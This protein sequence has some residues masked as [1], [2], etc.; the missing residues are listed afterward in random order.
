MDIRNP[1]RRG[2]RALRPLA[3]ALG[4]CLFALSAHAQDGAAPAPEAAPPTE[5]PA[6]LPA[7]DAD[8][9]LPE[10]GLVERRLDNGLTVWVLPRQGG[11]PK[12]DFVLAVRGGLASD[13]TEL[14]GMSN[15]LAGLLQE[16][17]ATRSS[18]QIAE[19]LERLGAS[20]GASASSDGVFVSASGLSSSARPLAALFAD[21]VRNPAFPENEVQLAKVNALQSLKAMQA[22]P[23]YQANLAMGRVLYGS[24]PYGNTLPTEAGINGTDIAGLQA[25]H[26][27]RFHPER[28][29]LVIAGPLDADAAVA[30]ANQ[31]F[32]DWQGAAG[33]LPEVAAPD[34]PQAPQFVLVPRSG[35]VQSAVRIGRPAFAA[36]DERAIPAALANTILGGGFD[37][38]LMRNL[39]EEKG[40]TYGAGSSFGLRALGGAFQAQADV[41]N[42]VTGAAIGEFLKEFE[43]MRER[44]V[45][46]DELERAKRFTAGTYLF[47]NQLQGAV[48]SALAGNW[49]LGRP[50]DYLS[51]YV[52]KTNAVTARQVQSVAREF[53]D[54]K[55]QS[56]VVV[57]DAGVAEQLA[58]YGAFR[59]D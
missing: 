45:P 20:L 4:A 29:L 50:A 55:Q 3:L 22:Q 1:S 34:Y 43:Q 2:T 23:S 37:S 30:L 49:L 10:L 52:E 11:L 26:A 56:I 57:G 38:R 59:Q 14:P 25:A 27:A 16:G 31:V 58:P 33:T 54:P 53:F 40:Y 51:T 35:S 15:L 12:V 32:G 9:P 7:Y 24:H 47:Q 8:R 44:P 6:G 19:E 5:L 28:A 17:T 39:R 48:A 41:R 36:D 46:A 21:V 18:V 13:P 42:E